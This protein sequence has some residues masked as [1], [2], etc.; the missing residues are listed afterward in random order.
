MPVGNIILP[1]ETFDSCTSGLF[2]C[3]GEWL[4]QSTQGLFW[5]GALIAFSIIAW[6][7]L[8][9]VFG[10]VRSFGFASFIGMM[11]SIWFAILGWMP[12]W[13]ATVFILI[14]VVGFIAMINTER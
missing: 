3:L 4:Y 7:A 10:N 8:I 12:W 5:V 11:G 1:S 14:G 13:I 2:F 9:N 6:L